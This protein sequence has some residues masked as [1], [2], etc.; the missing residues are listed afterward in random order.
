MFENN[1]LEFCSH[2]HPSVPLF[3]YVPMIS[4]FLYLALWVKDQQVALV[5]G[6]FVL[7]V[8]LWTLLEYIIHRWAFHYE[9]KSS[10]GKKFHFI[11]HGVHH[12]YPNDATRLVMPPGVSIPLAVVFGGSFMFLFRGYYPAVFAGF[13]AGYLGYDMIHYATHHF[14]MRGR[15]GA[16]LK[17]YHLR[18]HY[19]DD[20]S[21]FGV[22]TPIWD[23]VFGTRRKEAAAE[24][25]AGPS[26]ATISGD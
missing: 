6:L 24:R 22:S 18:H 12:D 19:Q 21:A 23:Y 4:F 17:R 3:I 26:L 7:G 14:A 13:G 20:H 10:L 16:A 2:V 9:P 1:F 5:A 15:I 25:A 11:I 8:L